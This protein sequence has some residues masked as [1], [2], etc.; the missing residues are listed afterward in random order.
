M[1][2]EYMVFFIWANSD[3][4]NIA[5]PTASLR[6]V[7]GLTAYTIR[8]LSTFLTRSR[9]RVESTMEVVQTKDAQ[10]YLPSTGLIRPTLPT[11]CIQSA[12]IGSPRRCIY[13]FVS[14]L[15]AAQRE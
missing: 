12:A 9:S 8:L 13:C 3:G 15:L 10:R 7:V 4:R 6:L 14:F 5:Y 1:K 11:T 2:Y